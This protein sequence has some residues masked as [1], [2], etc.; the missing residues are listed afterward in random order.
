MI[1]TQADEQQESEERGGSGAAEVGVTG[2]QLQMFM[3]EEGEIGKEATRS[4]KGRAVG[5]S[6]WA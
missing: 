3:S 6:D 2:P 1:S 4:T 5:G